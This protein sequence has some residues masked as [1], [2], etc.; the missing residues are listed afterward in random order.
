[1]MQRACNVTCHPCWHISHNIL[2]WVNNGSSWKEIQYEFQGMGIFLETWLSLLSGLQ[3]GCWVSSFAEKY[4]KKMDTALAG[5][6]N[7]SEV[8]II[9]KVHER[10]LLS[11]LYEG[12]LVTSTVLLSA[13]Y[14]EWQIQ[15]IAHLINIVR[16]VEKLQEFIFCTVRS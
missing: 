12:F 5:P 6:S 7:N 14:Y 16:L 15:N 3:V 1:M 11:P 9:V 13:K 2:F 4:S 8:F 10:S